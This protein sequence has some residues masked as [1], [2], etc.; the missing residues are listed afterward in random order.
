MFVK[1]GKLLIGANKSGRQG[2]GPNQFSIEAQKL[3]EHETMLEQMLTAQRGTS[4]V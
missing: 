1:N 3:R 4:G 2:Q